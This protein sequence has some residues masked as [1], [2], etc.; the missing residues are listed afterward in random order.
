MGSRPFCPGILILILG[1]KDETNQ[2]TPSSFPD[3]LPARSNLL[4]NRANRA[5]LKTLYTIIHTVRIMPKERETFITRQPPIGGKD[6]YDS[7]NSW[8]SDRLLSNSRRRRRDKL[9]G[10]GGGGEWRE[11]ESAM[12]VDL[13]VD[14]AKKEIKVKRRRG[15]G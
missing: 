14:G 4:S 6:D 13:G 2:R 5:R 3:M 12:E 9:R 1:T 10:E 8:I 7:E 11:K 15:H